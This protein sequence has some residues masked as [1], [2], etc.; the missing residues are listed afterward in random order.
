MEMKRYGRVAGVL[1][2]A[3]A[4]AGCMGP[5]ALKPMLEDSEAY[6][7]RYFSFDQVA[8]DIAK[9][10][11]A[12]PGSEPLGFKR[13]TAKGRAEFK[14]DDDSKSAVSPTRAEFEF[15]MVNDRDDGMMRRIDK[16]TRN[17]LPLMV[18]HSLTYHGLSSLIWQDGQASRGTALPMLSLRS[19]TTWSRLATMKENA[20]YDYAVSYGTGDALMPSYKSE[21]RCKSGTFRDAGSFV[22]GTPGKVVDL[23]CDDIN[24]SGVKSREIR[25]AWLSQYGVGLLTRVST[26]NGTTDF[27]YDSLS[28]Q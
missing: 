6:S 8:P 1:G 15:V 25:F 21:R 11:A 23:V 22:P 26:T 2:L 14:V 12:S 7:A 9:Q 3:L 5:T 10:A 28:A 17:G 19:I 20:N 4:T 18:E 27:K 13:L 24:N 16:R